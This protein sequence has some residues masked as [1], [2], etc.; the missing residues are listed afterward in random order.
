MESFFN[1]APDCLRSALSA[2]GQF[3]MKPAS[4]S[5]ALLASAPLSHAASSFGNV[6]TVDYVRSVLPSDDFI[7][8]IAIDPLSVTAEPVTNVSVSSNMYPGA[9]IDFCNVT[10]AYTHNGLNDTVHL[11]YWFPPPASFQNRFLATGGGGY[12]INSGTSTRGSLPGGVMY[13][14]VSGMTDGGFGSFETQVSDVILIQNGTMDRNALYMFGYQAIHEMTVLGK[15]FTQKFY[16]I[17]NSTATLSSNGTTSNSTTSKSTKLYAYYQGCSEGGREGMSQIQRFPDQFDGVSIGAP[18]MRYSFQQVQHLWAGFVQK[19]LEYFPSSCEA[20]YIT[21]ATIAACDPLDGK[22]D[23]VVARSDLCILEFD[24]DSIVGDAYS[25][26]ANF[27]AGG[28]MMGRRPSNIPAQNGTVSQE[29]VN[30]MKTILAGPK[31]SQD[32]Q[33]Y[34]SYQPGAS[35]D[36]A[37]TAYNSATGEWELSVSGLGGQYVTL[38]LQLLQLNNLPSLDGVTADTLRDWMYEGWTKYND[39]L[40]TNWPDLSALRDAGAKVLHYHGE[41]DGS[42]PAASS[43]RYYESVRNLLYGNLN[44]TEESY[45]ALGEWYKFFTIPG[46]GHCGP[47]RAQPNGP[48]PQNNLEVLINWVESGLA[49]NTLNGTVL[50]GDHQGENQQICAWPLRPQWSNDTSSPSCVYDKTSLDTWM[51]DLDSFA[52]PVY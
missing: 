31:D 32:R 41:Q 3:L 4:W 27:S 43:V 9:V 45:K 38:F 47:N 49:P 12:S 19:T 46:A 5:I 15:E 39:V 7:N 22:K 52:M 37:A 17:G 24:L 48:W 23:G 50:Q 21:N 40:Q 42:I 6:C 35:I 36:N 11:N 8:G 10:L 30:V 14:A 20:S 16:G 29:A 28:G 44:S 51:Y 13:G 26:P 2:A 25:C 18:A 1:I 34:F 33:V